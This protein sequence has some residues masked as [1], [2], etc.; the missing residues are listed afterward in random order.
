MTRF[1]SDMNIQILVPKTPESR[2]L[3]DWIESGT[4]DALRRRYMKSLYFG[5]SK[6]LK[7]EHLIEVL[8]Q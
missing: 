6:D 2:R 4:A 3:I 7:G 1:V 5:I 8:T